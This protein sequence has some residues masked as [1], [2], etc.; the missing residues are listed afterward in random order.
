V[1]APPWLK[2]P[3]LW[4]GKKKFKYRLSKHAIFPIILLNH[5]GFF[6]LLE[7]SFIIL[8]NVNNQIFDMKLQGPPKTCSD[9]ADVLV[10]ISKYL[11]ANEVILFPPTK[12]G[13]V[14]FFG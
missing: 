4:S 14:N 12:Q 1:G 8:S 5:S 9:G 2:A 10:C 11:L 6:H 3:K 7:V 13:S